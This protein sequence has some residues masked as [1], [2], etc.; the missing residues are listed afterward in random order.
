V[1]PPRKGYHRIVDY[2]RTGRRGWRKF[3]PSWRL[4][5]GSLAGLLAALGAL[6]AVVYASVRVPDA[7]RLSM[8]TAT[9]YEYSDGTVF[10]TAG[11]Q[12]RVIVPLA[13]IP[14]ALRQAVI[15]VENPTFWSDAG[16]APRGIARSLL[17][18]VEGRPLEGGSTITQQFV[19]NAYLTDQQT[20][21]RK[22]SEIFIAVK[23]TRAYPKRQILGDY[24]NTVYF[25]RS[26]YGADAAAETY[27]GVPVS[28]ITDPARAAY[29]AALV[30]EPTVLSRTDPSAQARLR[31]RWN[32]VLDDMVRSGVL[33]RAARA[34]VRWP[35]VLPARTGT[36]RD[37]AGVNE[38]AMA[39]VANGYLDELHQQDPAVPDSATADAGGD[40]IVT[41]FRHADMIAAV[42]AVRAGLFAGLD[43]AGRGQAAVDRGVQAGLATVDARTGELLAFYPGGSDY[44]DATQAQIEPGSQLEVFADAARVPDLGEGSGAAVPISLWTMM[45]RVGLTQN[46]VADPAELPEPLTKLEHDPALALG[47]A[48]ESPARMAAAFAIFGDGGIYHDLAMALSVTVN[49]HRVWTFTPHGTPALSPLSSR[50]LGARALHLGV[51]LV[52]GSAGESG[53]AGALSGTAVAKSEKE[54]LAAGAGTEN[55]AA[56]FG[57]VPGTIGG[58]QSAWYTGLAGGTVTSVALWDTQPGPH[59]TVTLRSLA[60]LG[61][62]PASGTA[63]WPIA[64]WSGYVKNTPDGPGGA[65]TPSPAPAG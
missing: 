1:R 32:L 19:K 27:F 59:G 35:A 65:P 26:S 18:D 25:G 12:N 55:T 52:A 5:T 45:G 39:Q 33:T 46:L 34:A 14:P 4:V 64:I 57:G 22:L 37:S 20:L 53:G 3:V 30:N 49:G 10:Y 60:G 61:G 9:R 21:T 31:Q 54:A 23:I 16:I 58:D 2:P 24:L 63:S 50:V 44:N 48:P 6:V 29:L 42:R 13:Q 47:I 62:V 36:V 8:P 51:P 56:L 43:P 15:A 7:A 28:A 40:V 17:N 38:S 11:L 41:T